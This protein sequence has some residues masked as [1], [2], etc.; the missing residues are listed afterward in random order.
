MARSRVGVGGFR[1]PLA[2][3]ISAIPAPASFPGFV[4]TMRERGAIFAY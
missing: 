3:S 2:C 1:E 4:P